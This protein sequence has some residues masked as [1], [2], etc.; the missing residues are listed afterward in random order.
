MLG[1]HLS[2]SGGHVNALLEAERLKMESVQIFTR[3]QRQWKAPPLD[4]AGVRDWLA[5]LH[6][7]GWTEVVSHASYLINLA[8]P[9]P[10]M[11]QKSV[12]AMT[13]EIERCEEMEIPYAVVHPGAHKEAGVIEGLKHLVLG[14][15]EITAR[16]S[17][18]RA[19]VCLETTVG[20]GT[21]LGG[22]FEHLA[23]VRETVNEPE[24][25]GTCLDTCHV[26]AAGYDISTE[27]KT[28]AMF[29]EF[30]E[31]IGL[32]HLCCFHFNDSMHPMGSHKDRHA[33]IGDGHL[34]V[35]AF[36]FILNDPRFENVPK[37]LE[38]EKGTTE[39]G[40]SLDAINIRRLR[41]LIRTEDDSIQATPPSVKT[42]KTTK[43]KKTKSTKT[44]K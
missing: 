3:N 40:T 1:S 37:I 41:K 28:G 26:F 44:K 20:G 23:A 39:K 27:T 2:T 8:T 22:V 36:A 21:R 11:W 25:V 33:H 38:T 12:D 7:L 9:E 35:D 16:T 43:K 5:A 15:N 4:P 17:G 30:D 34:G 42:T 31:V 32:E 14:I 19:K 13:L 18:F 10:E 24:R 29:D 6:R